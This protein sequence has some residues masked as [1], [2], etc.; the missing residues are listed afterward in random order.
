MKKVICAL[1]FLATAGA[2]HSSATMTPAPSPTPARRPPTATGSTTGAA[3]SQGAV[4]GFL[5]A[6]KNQDLQAMSNYWGDKQGLAR[7]RYPVVELN[8]REILMMCY[9]K[10]DSAQILSDAP[11]AGGGRTTTVQLRNGSLTASTNF[12]TVTGP[13]GRWYVLSVP[14]IASLQRACSG[15]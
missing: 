3:D 11:S 10:H 7:D 12:L 4:L 9:L 1:V 2:C 14:D 15:R 13:D 5:A 6:V 8:Q